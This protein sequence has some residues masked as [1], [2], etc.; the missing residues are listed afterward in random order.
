MATEVNDSDFEAEVLASDLP[1]VVDFWAEWCAPCK[2]LDPIFDDLSNELAGRVKIVKLDV[3]NNPDT[4]ARYNVRNM[5]TIILFK[6]GEPAD[7]KVG[8]AQ[9]RVSLL[10]WME[11]YAA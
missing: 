11:E 4:A 10:K 2:A 7:M 1:V 8:A 3:G 5:P 6:D 9:S